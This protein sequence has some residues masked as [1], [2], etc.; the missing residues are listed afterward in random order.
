M[1]LAT[2]PTTKRATPIPT[3]SI[4]P[5]S[6]IGPLSVTVIQGLPLTIMHT[7]KLLIVS[8]LGLL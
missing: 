1:A 4:R 3:D 5:L 8:K 2:N 6:G 7:A